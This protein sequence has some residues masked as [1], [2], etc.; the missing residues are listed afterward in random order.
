M[1]LSDDLGEFLRAVFA[2]QDGVTHEGEETIIRDRDSEK[3]TGWGTEHC[4]LAKV[5]HT[6]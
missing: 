2:G 4:G 1:L 3:L 5:R 6:R